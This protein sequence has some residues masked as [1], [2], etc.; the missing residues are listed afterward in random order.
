MQTNIEISLLIWI[1]HC[2]LGKIIH[3][4]IIIL[5]IIIIIIEKEKGNLSFNMENHRTIFRF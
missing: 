1:R 2:Q 4:I 5:I 3:F